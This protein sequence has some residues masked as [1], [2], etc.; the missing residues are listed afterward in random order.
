MVNLPYMVAWS[1][2]V[3]EISKFR[4]GL[5]TVYIG[6]YGLFFTIFITH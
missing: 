5:V 1:F 3:D 4:R 2:G 6:V